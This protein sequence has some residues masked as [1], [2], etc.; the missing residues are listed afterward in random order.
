M[1]KK[2]ELTPKQKAFV[3]E[4]IIDFNASRA[5]LVARYSKKTAPFI[6]AENLRKPQI[7]AAIQKAI[8]K[9]EEK[10]GRTAE[11]V[12]NLLWSAAELDPAEYSTIEEGGEVRMK[13][14]DQIKPEV[15]KLLSKIKQKRKI[16]ESADGSKIYCDDDLEYTIPNKDKMIELLM[17]HHGLLNDKVNHTLDVAS[18]LSAL[19]PSMAEMVKEKLRQLSEGKR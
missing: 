16:T 9:R 6:G 2:G 5:A 10:T 18:I 17:R 7:Q 19:P 3:D 1:A 14:F 15:R 12:L 8:K 4:Y 11:D 13:T